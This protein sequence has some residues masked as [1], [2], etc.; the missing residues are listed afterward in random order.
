MAYDDISPFKQVIETYSDIL[1]SGIPWA[2]VR[3]GEE[4]ET[5]LASTNDSVLHRI[6]SGLSFTP[7]ESYDPATMVRIEYTRQKS[8]IPL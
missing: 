2:T 4:V 6:W 3:Y 5:Y 7:Y 8:H 1:A